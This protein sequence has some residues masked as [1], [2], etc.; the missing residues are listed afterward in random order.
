MSKKD[1]NSDIPEVTEEDFPIESWEH[2]PAKK[3]QVTM[4]LDSAVIAIF[5]DAGS[6][7]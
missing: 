6:G 5:N 1:K 7:N 3:Q 4:R 2:S